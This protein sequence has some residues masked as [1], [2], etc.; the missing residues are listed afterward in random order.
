[1][2]LILSILVLV[3]LFA[4]KQKEV[5]FGRRVLIAMALGVAFGIFFPSTAPNLDV[6]GQV[7]IRSI[8]MIV[9]PLVISVI[10]SSMTSIEDKNKLKS[11][12]FKT[13]FWLLLTTLIAAVISLI[14]TLIIDPGKGMTFVMDESFKAREIPTLKQ[15]FL[16]MIPS[17]PIDDMAK[18]KMIPVIVFSVLIALGISYESEFG[19]NV[20]KPV[21]DFFKGFSKVMFRVTSM[22]LE[23]T[24]YGVFALM[25]SVS[26]KYGLNSLIPLIKVILVIYIACLIQIV[27]VHGGLLLLVGKTNPIEFFKN[28]NRALIVAFTTRSSYGTLPITIRSLTHNVKVPEATAN[29]AAPIGA[30][31]GMNGC[32]GIYPVMVAIFVANVFNIPMGIYDYS[33]LILVTTV[34]SIGTAGVPGTASIMATVVLTALGLPI[35]GLAMLMGIDVILDMMRTLTNVSGASVVTYLVSKS[36][37]KEKLAASEN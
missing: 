7:Y 10:I 1:M 15:V 30:T 31:M 5:L 32:G 23:L 29:F 4:L 27:F 12:G 37:D 2:G 36:T 25:M 22:V 9:M 26:S 35:E 13:I 11:L 3:L 6:V 34:A 21:K 17:N 14:V 20:V 19:A 28:I 8:K 18:N 16:D 24:P 33:L